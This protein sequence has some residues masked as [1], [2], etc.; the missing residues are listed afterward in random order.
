[1]AALMSS[2]FGTHCTKKKCEY[3]RH[4]LI[5]P[6]SNSLRPDLPPWGRTSHYSETA[7]SSQAEYMSTANT[8]AFRI[9]TGLCVIYHKRYLVCDQTSAICFGQLTHNVI[10]T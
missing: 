2:Y 9:E 6:Q 3:S 7:F 5:L 8:P 4:V 1:M 10:T